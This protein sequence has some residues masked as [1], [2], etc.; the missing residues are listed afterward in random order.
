M[1]RLR[2]LPLLVVATLATMSLGASS[3]LAA[4]SSTRA[5]A[6]GCV[7]AT[8]IE[9]IIDDSGSMAA[10]DPN[11]LRVKGLKLL[12][13]T[14]SSGTTLGAVE[15]GG[16]FF[17]SDT[18]PAADTVFAPEPVGPNAT[19]M[20][21]ALDS[22]IHADNGGTDYNAAFAQSDHDNPAA[23]A[24]IFL[25]DGGHD[26]GT[27]NNG[28]LVHRVPTYVISFGAG[29]SS[30]DRARLQGIANDTGGV[31]YPQTDSSRLQSVMNSIG[32]ALTCQT[33]PQS[34]T[35]NLQQGKSKTH[36]VAIG[37]HTRAV[38]IAL[39]WASPQD[40]FS[41]SHLRLVRHGRTI[42]NAARVR[43]LK[44]KRTTSATFIVLTV[45]RLSKGTLRFRVR[46]TRIGSG[47]PKAVLTTQVRQSRKH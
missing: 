37:A 17:S 42:A 32:A 22:K 31:Y 28:H 8:N 1:K 34:F 29:I 10:T 36:G 20:G 3:G 14:L 43:A 38:Q 4:K 30:D 25:T 39:T 2:S 21:N 13:N 41:I 26:I 15:F 5:H 7:P 45:S 24:R 27:Y 44:V 35:D 23:Q 12:I 40:K 6:A 11:T 19:A 16:N 33:P 46:A 9:A 47:S 18:T